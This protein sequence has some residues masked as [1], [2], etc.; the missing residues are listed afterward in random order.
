MPLFKAEVYTADGRQKE[1]R[2]E[3]AGENELLRELISDGLTVI[4]IKEENSRSLNIFSGSRRRSA[5]RSRSQPHF[6][7]GCH[8]LPVEPCGG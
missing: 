2:K 6:C 4:N 3:A 5:A 7:P 1:L 8:H